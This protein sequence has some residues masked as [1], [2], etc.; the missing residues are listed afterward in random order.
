[1]GH[2]RDGQEEAGYI[3]LKFTEKSWLEMEIC[4]LLEYR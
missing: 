4:E 2:M 1:M 3:P